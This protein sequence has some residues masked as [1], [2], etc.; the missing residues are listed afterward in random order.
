MYTFKRW[1]LMCDLIEISCVVLISYTSLFAKHFLYFHFFFLRE[2]TFSRFF[3]ERQDKSKLHHSCL[4]CLF[5]FSPLSESSLWR[6]VVLFV[7]FLNIKSFLFNFWLFVKCDFFFHFKLNL[8]LPWLIQR[9]FPTLKSFRITGHCFA[10][11]NPNH[12]YS[13]TCNLSTWK[14]SSE[15]RHL[16]RIAILTNVRNWP[17]NTTAFHSW[18]PRPSKSIAF[19]IHIQLGPVFCLLSF[20]TIFFFLMIISSF[21]QPF[22]YLSA[23]FGS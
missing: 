21:S 9:F 1:R 20:S 11:A 17:K 7:C 10:F 18:F 12:L 19:N 13:N 22:S 2:R 15:R 4:T 14:S 6:P 16:I 5:V 8:F 3:H 23:W